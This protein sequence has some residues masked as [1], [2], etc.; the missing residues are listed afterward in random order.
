[1]R[2]A[3]WGVQWSKVLP[4]TWQLPYNR[5]FEWVLLIEIPEITYWGF[6]FPLVISLS[7]CWPLTPW[8]S[9][10]ILMETQQ[11]LFV[12]KQM[13]LFSWL[14]IRPEKWL[15]TPCPV[16]CRASKAD[17]IDVNKAS[18]ISILCLESS[19]K[20]LGR[21]ILIHI[22]LLMHEF[23]F[24]PWMSWKDFGHPWVPLAAQCI[25]TAQCTP[26]SVV[27]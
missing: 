20:R 22:Y 9:F 2:K 15:L 5:Q 26:A 10:A 18:N 12:C 19:T 14:K 11:R 13:Q 24:Q 8:L 17:W 6:K 23:I 1:M 21:A 25:Y 27:L 16:T 4:Y 3:K 7:P